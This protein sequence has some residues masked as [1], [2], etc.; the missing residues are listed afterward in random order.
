MKLFTYK[1]INF[2]FIKLFEIYYSKKYKKPKFSCMLENSLAK[3]N[4]Y[5]LK[6]TY[7]D[8][9]RL[10]EVTEGNISRSFSNPERGFWL[11]R[12][13]VSV[14]GRFLFESYCLQNI[15]FTTGDTIIDCGANSGDLTLQLQSMSLQLNYVAFEPNPA[16]FQVLKQNVTMP[17]R[18]LLN[19][20]LGEKS[21]ELDF[22]VNTTEA[23]SSLIKPQSYSK[24]IKS[25]VITLDE[26]FDGNNLGNVRLL[27]LE[28]EG[29]EPEILL[30]ARRALQKIEFVAVDGGYERGIECE[31]TLTTVANILFESGFEMIDI[32][33]P[34]YRAL[35]RKKLN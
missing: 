31:Q 10:Y 13:G 20:A 25:K 12:S 29:F 18:T 6:F 17:N 23:D 27:K 26:Y 1:V 2:I 35:F 34:W 19:N 22:Y 9:I 24:L 4:G 30:G 28:A 3:L 33:F 21:G 16:D 11:Y 32:Y 15:N 8:D 14:R 5:D 7:H